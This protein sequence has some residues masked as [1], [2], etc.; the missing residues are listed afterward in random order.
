M[1]SINLNTSNGQGITLRE[2][3]HS[4]NVPYNQIQN[5]RESLQ[6]MS[7]DQFYQ[8]IS[9]NPV[10]QNRDVNIYRPYRD[11]H[12]YQWDLDNE[13]SLRRMLTSANRHTA[14]QIALSE[15]NIIRMP[16]LR[17]YAPVGAM[18]F[19][20][21]AFY[22]A[23]VTLNVVYLENIAG[24]RYERGNTIEAGQCTLDQLR[25]MKLAEIERPL[26]TR[27]VEEQR[28]SQVQY[29]RLMAHM[30]FFVVHGFFPRSHLNNY[31]S[32]ETNHG[33]FII[34]TEVQKN[35]PI[36]ERIRTAA[37]QAQLVAID[38]QLHQ[39]IIERI[40]NQIAYPAIGEDLPAISTDQITSFRRIVDGHSP[41]SGRVI[42]D[43]VRNNNRMA[44]Q[45][46]NHL[47]P[48]TV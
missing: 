27:S 44:T 23:L 32:S 16:N 39:E 33:Q 48:T 42:P 18:A 9:Y 29:C 40:D 8:R 31:L 11:M 47:H 43:D 14:Y 34:G 12:P 35:S 30:I 3:E 10:T 5:L 45:I 7:P 15:K 38:Q 20:G 41:D 6:G 4:E 13:I 28:K 2:L 1:S 25:I 24:D 19:S 21:F 37:S 46:L 26:N 36:N 22:N 17:E